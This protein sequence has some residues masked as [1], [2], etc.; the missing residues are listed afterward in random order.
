M[1]FTGYRK[2]FL[3][4]KVFVRSPVVK[5]HGSKVK[6]SVSEMYVVVPATSDDDILSW[7]PSI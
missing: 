1:P 3:D 5:M 7:I 2:S 6:Q 4:T